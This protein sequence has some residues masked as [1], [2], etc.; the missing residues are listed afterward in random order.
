MGRLVASSNQA[1]QPSRSKL[2]R[3][4]DE[5]SPGCVRLPVLGLQGW[6]S[7]VHNFHVCHALDPGHFAGTLRVHPHPGE[8]FLSCESEFIRGQSLSWAGSRVAADC[9]EM[10]TPF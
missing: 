8:S 6:S 10:S 7:G 1:W 3:V 9:V 5:C 4:C 2:N